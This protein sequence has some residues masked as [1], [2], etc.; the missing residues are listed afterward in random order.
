MEVG[1]P[2]RVRML[3]L[4]KVCG[5]RVG[6]ATLAIDES[7]T[8]VKV[9]RAT[10]NVPGANCQPVNGAGAPEAYHGLSLYSL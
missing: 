9:V 8:F 3:I 6:S 4:P 1:A 10:A 2:G 7:G 5:I